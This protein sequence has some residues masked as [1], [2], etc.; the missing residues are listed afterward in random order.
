VRPSLSGLDRDFEFLRKE[1]LTRMSLG[2]DRKK[3][4]LQV[5]ISVTRRVKALNGWERTKG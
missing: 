2:K 4:I 5:R 3:P 1:A